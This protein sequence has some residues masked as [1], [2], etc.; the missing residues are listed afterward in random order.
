M[1][2]TTADRVVLARDIQASL[3]APDGVQTEARL[4]HL[5]GVMKAV[6]G[7]DVME[8][9]RRADIVRARVVFIFVARAEGFSQCTIGE[10][11]SMNH[12]SV[13]FMESKMA[14]ALSLPVAYQDYIGLYNQFT[15]AIL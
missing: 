9:S 3:T 4:R 11:L 2:L 14:D 6:S 10:F 15:N 7:C 12:S 5:A 8:R 1:R 13:S